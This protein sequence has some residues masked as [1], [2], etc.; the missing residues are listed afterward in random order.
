MTNEEFETNKQLLEIGREIGASEAKEALAKVSDSHQMG[1]NAGRAQAFGAM[2]L[3]AEFL[4]WKSYSRII[5]AREF[6]QIQIK[7]Q[8][9][10][11]NLRTVEEY[12][13][14]LGFSP[15]AGFRN[16]KI[17]RALTPTEIQLL[18][19][20]GFTRKDLLSYASLPDEKRM[21][22]RDGK[23]INIESADRQEI[24][25]IIEQVLEENLQVKAE[26]EKTVKA[27]ERVKDQ[28]QEK[29]DHQEKQ[30]ADLKGK[31][32]VA[33]GE[34]GCTADEVSF[35]KT[36]E[37]HETIFN[38]LIGG[39][40][41]MVE[42]EVPGPTAALRLIALLNQM[43]MESNAWYKLAYDYHAPPDSA[44]EEEWQQPGPI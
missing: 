22:I 5:D 26:A 30:I 24:R 10:T 13:E 36:L 4:Q 3:I 32:E 37:K 27:I 33:S 1:V 40:R 43:R 28:K 11:R 34:R 23:V 38:G 12:L 17:A 21:E 20:V 16:L 8:G 19:E 9:V 15:S 41:A 25:E 39:M 42:G 29:I 2:Q 35:C 7:D 31:L 14:Y 18:G 44:P 6:V